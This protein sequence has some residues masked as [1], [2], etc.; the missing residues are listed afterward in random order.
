VQCGLIFDCDGVLANVEVELHL[1]AFNR[2]FAE[3]GVDWYWKPADYLRALNIAGGKE[4]LLSLFTDP[5]FLAAAGEPAAGEERRRLVDQWHRRKTDLFGE[6]INSAEIRPRPGVRRLAEEADRAGWRLAVASSGA[7]RSVAAILNSVLGPALASRFSVVSGEMVQAKKP[8]PEV[9]LLTARA[10]GLP[11]ARCVVIEDTVAGARAAIAS[12][13]RCVV[14]PTAHSFH[15]DFSD[16][17]I[18]VSSLGDPGE[19]QAI[20]LGGTVWRS[21]VDHIELSALAELIRSPQVQPRQCGGVWYGRQR[22]AGFR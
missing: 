15:D 8:D 20:T 2:A 19:V 21:R 9:Y 1:A 7:G 17:D 10:I 18:V 13:M 3:S 22:S 5:D 14:T 12:G 11:P 16:T 4:R 6:L